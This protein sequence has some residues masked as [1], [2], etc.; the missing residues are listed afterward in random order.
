M[1]ESCAKAKVF[2]TCPLTLDFSKPPTHEVKKIICGAIDCSFVRR[3]P[4]FWKYFI[5]N[6]IF[7]IS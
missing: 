3:N 7:E 5:L 1:K 4:F 6:P 2:G